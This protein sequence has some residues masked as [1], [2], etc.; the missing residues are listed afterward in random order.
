VATPSLLWN[1]IQTFL[2]SATTH[3]TDDA[4][5][6]AATL[7]YSSRTSS[8]VKVVSL[9]YGL[10]ALPKI[11]KGR[12]STLETATTIHSIRISRCRRRLSGHR[13][14]SHNDKARTDDYGLVSFIHRFIHPPPSTTTTT[15]QDN[16]KT[17]GL[18]HDRKPHNRRPEEH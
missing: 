11:R 2:T 16:T 14:R 5:V 18:L 4:P 7:Y 1:S 12:I 10:M 3:T 17:R 8:A 13:H 9:L 15:S 6:V